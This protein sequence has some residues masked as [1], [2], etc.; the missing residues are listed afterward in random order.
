MSVLHKAVPTRITV[1]LFVVLLHLN[2]TS[3]RTA[4]LI[5]TKGIGEHTPNGLV[6][7]GFH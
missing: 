2:D 1:F 7:C 3:M 6:Y 4:W 5:L